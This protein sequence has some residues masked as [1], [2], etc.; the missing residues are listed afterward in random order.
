MRLR[1]D[2]NARLRY[3][4]LNVRG[5]CRLLSDQIVKVLFFVGN[6]FL[7]LVDAWLMCIQKIVASFANQS[8]C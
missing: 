1:T 4:S 2:R 6:L 8:L 3:F 7:V 5:V